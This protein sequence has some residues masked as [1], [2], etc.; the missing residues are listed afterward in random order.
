MKN[1]FISMVLFLSILSVVSFASG[2]HD[3][4][5]AEQASH[6]E[7]PILNNMCPV[8]TDMKVNP[9]IFTDY[10]GKRVHFCCDNCKAKFEHE[11][12]KYLHQLPQFAP[13]TQSKHPEHRHPQDSSFPFFKFVKPM[14][15]VTLVLVVLTV[16]AGLLRRKSPKFLLKWHKRMG[17]LTLI[18]ALIHALLVLLTH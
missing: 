15:I 13:G 9:E 4:S 2:G 17:I 16:S 8:M 7:Q 1:I 12:E 18:S 11:P 3:H 5:A 14:G 10:Q 6:H